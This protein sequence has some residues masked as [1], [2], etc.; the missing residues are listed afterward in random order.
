MNS[1]DDLIAS[2]SNKATPVKPV[3]SPMAL[4]T[5]SIGASIVYTAILVAILGVRPNL[6][7]FLI[8]PYSFI[9]LWLLF[10]LLASSLWS[11]ICY[12]YPD[13]YGHSIRTSL[14]YI[15]LGLL[16]LIIGSQVD[17]TFFVTVMKELPHLITCLSCI[18]AASILPSILLFILTQRGAT[19]API[20]SGAVITLA[21]VSIGCIALRLHEPSNDM[22]H[23]LVSHYIPVFLFAGLGAFIGHT[24]LKW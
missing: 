9:E 7:T 14:P 10:L 20:K 6:Q 17:S 23:I 5:V 24:I 4:W 22:G 18:A 16:V 12:A 15:I 21:A 11:S 19:V 8:Q 2:L 3:A 13:Q 1:T